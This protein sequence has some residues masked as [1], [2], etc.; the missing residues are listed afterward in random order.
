MI[1]AYIA[2][3]SNLGNPQRQ[4]SLAYAAIAQL[5]GSHIQAASSLYGS[6][7]IGPGTQPDYLN[8][9]VCLR[10]ALGPNELLENLQQIELAQGRVREE[11]W[12][13]RTLDLDILLYDDRQ[14]D[15]PSLTIP[16]PRM[17]QRNF[18]LYPLLEI[19]GANF[20]LPDG[21]ELGTLVMD[22]PRG[23]LAQNAPDFTHHCPG[24]S[25]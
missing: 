8:A 5:P 6:A 14:L 16:H 18:V 20:Q 19:A 24:R 12:A 22:C 10:T 11:H 2:L 7:A 9:V 17:T 23:D 15:S 21:R 25:H 1:T 4:L 3:G 13:A